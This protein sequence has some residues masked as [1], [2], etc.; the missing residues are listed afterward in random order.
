MI[1]GIQPTV[2]TLKI[3]GEN[4]N[5]LSTLQPALQSFLS[6]S[7]PGF[8]FSGEMKVNGTQ[9]PN[10]STFDPL[11]SD[12]SMATNWNAFPLDSATGSQ[13]LNMSS[14]FLFRNRENTSGL[15]LSNG[16]Q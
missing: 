6:S 15:A 8:N 4:G 1:R 9:I 3:N 14:F 10:P 7:P 16:T 5:V 13:S 2:T 12:F 11:S